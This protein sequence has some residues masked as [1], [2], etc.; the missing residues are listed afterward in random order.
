[1]KK[2][3]DRNANKSN[4]MQKGERRQRLKGNQD[5]VGNEKNKSQYTSFD[6]EEL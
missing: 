5:N 4:P 1:M 2:N 3:C 6:G